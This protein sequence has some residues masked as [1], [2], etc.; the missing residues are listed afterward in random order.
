MF[1]ESCVIQELKVIIIVMLKVTTLV[2]MT[3]HVCI[4]L[5][6]YYDENRICSFVA[7]LKYYEVLY[8]G[9]KMPFTVFQYLFSFQ[10]YSCF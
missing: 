9:R 3:K 7:V 6:C 5:K 2:W 1:E 4:T 8:M 10:R